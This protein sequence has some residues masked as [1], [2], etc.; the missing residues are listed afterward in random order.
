MIFNIYN[1]KSQDENQKYTMERKL[2]T[3]NISEKA[4]ICED[5]NAHYFWWN[6]EISNSVQANELISWINRFTCKLINISNEIIYTSHS[7]IS[8]SMFNLTFATWKIAENIVD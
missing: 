7:E 4:I 1:E 3:I 5:F 8:Q 2:T 6:L